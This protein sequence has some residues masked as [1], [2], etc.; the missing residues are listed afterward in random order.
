MRATSSTLD[1]YQLTRTL[2]SGFSAKVKL[3]QDEHGKQFAIKVFDL[4]NTE[5]TKR[6][7]HFVKQEV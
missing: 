6:K 7:M 2:G 3:A 5:R 4:D 1:G